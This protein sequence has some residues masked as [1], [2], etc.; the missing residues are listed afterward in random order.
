M[1]VPN[2]SDGKAQ[3]IIGLAAVGVAL[4]A[5]YQVTNGIGKVKDSVTDG[6]KYVKDSVTNFV[7]DEK[8]PINGAAQS[9]VGE[10]RLQAGFDK[11]FDFFNP[12]IKKQH[13]QA[14][15]AISGKPA[16]KLSPMLT[17]ALTKPAEEYRFYQAGTGVKK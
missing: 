16:V 15:K 7:T 4:Y 14:E 13:E 6:A 11:I 2:I 1:K 9:L 3:I 5:V 12:A 10:Q 8:N 17:T